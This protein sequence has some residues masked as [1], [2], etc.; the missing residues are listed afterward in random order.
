M[1]EGIINFF[2][3]QGILGVVCLIEGLVIRSIYSELKNEREKNNA[4]QE[5]RRIDAIEARDQVTSVLPV[6]QQSLTN[7]TDKIALSKSRRS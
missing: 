2:F 6:I 1:D 5:A 4:L 3:T 7:I